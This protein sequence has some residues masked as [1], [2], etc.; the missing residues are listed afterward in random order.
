MAYFGN[1]SHIRGFQSFCI[2]ICFC[3]SGM[4]A[5]AEE[6]APAATEKKQTVTLEQF[7][8]NLPENESELD[9]AGFVNLKKQGPLV[10]LDV[11]SKESFAARHLKESVN[12]PLTDLTEKTLPQAV[13]DKNARIVLVCDYSF[14]PTRMMSMT[15]QAYPVLKINGYKNIYRLNLWSGKDQMVLEDE[16]QKVLAFEGTNVK[17]KAEIRGHMTNFRIPGAGDEGP[18][19]GKEGR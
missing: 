19:R 16:Q 17:K 2:M 3:F 18:V 14:F 7:K 15:L 9:L 4:A 13:P 1:G 5:N 12:L 6:R 11:R 10:V 8:E